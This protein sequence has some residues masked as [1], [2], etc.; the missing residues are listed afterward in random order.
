MDKVGI[1]NETVVMQPPT[2][3]Y[4]KQPIFTSCSA[5]KHRLVTLL[6]IEINDHDIVPLFLKGKVE[7]V[8]SPIQLHDLQFFDRSGE[9]NAS[10]KRV[11][12]KIILLVSLDL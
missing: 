12:C 8:Y 6:A 7:Y 1:Q 4:Q 2:S 5:S 9:K 11:Q 3:C 10:N